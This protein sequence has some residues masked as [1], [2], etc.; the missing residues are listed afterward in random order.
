MYDEHDSLAHSR[1]DAV[2][3]YA[4]I[5]THVESVDLGDVEHFTL[6]TGHCNMEEAGMIVSQRS[7]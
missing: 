6:Y 4:Q 5:G 2:R 7:Y 3:C 1:R